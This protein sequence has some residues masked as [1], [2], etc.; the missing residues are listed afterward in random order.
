M[1]KGVSSKIPSCIIY[2]RKRSFRFMTYFKKEQKSK[3]LTRTRLTL[4]YVYV[5]MS[6]SGI[7]LFLTT[8]N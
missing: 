5:I 2:E 7:S 6:I 4:H 3:L 8:P 1:R